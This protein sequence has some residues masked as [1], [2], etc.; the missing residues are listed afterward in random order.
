MKANDLKPLIGLKN[1]TE[2]VVWNTGISTDDLQEL[3]KLNSKIRFVE[4]FRDDGKPI[5]LTVPQIKNKQYVFSIPF[6]LLIS[7]PISGAV[8][9]YTMNGTDPD[10]IKSA[11]YKP[12]IIISS[13][14]NIRARAYKKGWYGSD[15]VN[16][17][18]NK[19]T[20]IPDTAIIDNNNGG[21]MLIDQELGSFLPFD[22]KWVGVPFEMVINVTFIKPVSLNTIGLGCLRLNG[23]QILFPAEVI[24]LGGTKKRKLTEV[25]R[26][27]PAKSLKNDPDKRTIFESKLTTNKPLTYFQIRVKPVKPQPWLPPQ[28][29]ASVWVDELF[30]N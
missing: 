4:G 2:L 23:Q 10:S 17:N 7:H 21:K 30:F 20:Y 24:I 5:K 18:Y 26:I 19:G 8:I 22:G 15:I 28:K 12:G 1:L 9:R 25:G 16:I 3:R 11:I 29:V 13:D 14:V 27:K 6:E